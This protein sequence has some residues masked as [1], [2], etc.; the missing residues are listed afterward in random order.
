MKAEEEDVV[1]I[2]YVPLYSGSLSTVL[3]KR[4]LYLSLRSGAG[5]HEEVPRKHYHMSLQVVA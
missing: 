1:E 3:L 2:T 5:R 4:S